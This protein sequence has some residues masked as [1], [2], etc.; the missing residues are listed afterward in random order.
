MTNWKK[1][2]RCAG[3]EI[4]LRFETDLD[5]SSLDFQKSRCR[6]KGRMLNQKACQSSYCYCYPMLFGSSSNQDF[7]CMEN[8]TLFHYTSK[9]GVPFDLTLATPPIKPAVHSWSY[10]HDPWGQQ[11]HGRSI[12]TLSYLKWMTAKFLNE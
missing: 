3:P 11:K 10:S 9:F 1:K 12:P 8:K 4:F 6:L 5:F 2:S 7:A